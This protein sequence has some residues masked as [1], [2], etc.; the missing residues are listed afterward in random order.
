MSFCS[1]DRL[2]VINVEAEELDIKILVF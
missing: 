2:D 1:D